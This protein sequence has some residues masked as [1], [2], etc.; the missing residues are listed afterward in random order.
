MEV[1]HVVRFIVTFVGTLVVLF[2]LAVVVGGNLGTVEVQLCLLLAL[3]VAIGAVVLGRR[4]AR[5][6]SSD[7]L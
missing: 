6:V 7:E 5:H 3:A 1:S 2:V 4:R